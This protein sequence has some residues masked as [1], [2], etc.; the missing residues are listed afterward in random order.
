MPQRV[1]VTGGLGY[2]GSVA[3]EHFLAAGYEV[4]ALDNLMYGAGQGLFHLCA[5]PAF[6]FIKGDV[7]DESVMRNAIKGV[8]AI[9][10]LAGIVGASACDRDPALAKSVNLES[11]RLLNRL[12]SPNQLVV[13]PNT[14]SGYGATTGSALCTEDTPL[15]P[16]SLYGRTKCEAE[17]TLL[18]SPN[19]VT[20]RLAT[21][22]GLS[23]RMRLDLLVNHFVYSAVKDGYIV[24]FEKDFKRNFVHV[25]D[26]A[27]CFLHALV[28]GSKMSGRPYNLGLD[29]A[30][31]SKE[32]LA[33]AVKKQVPKFYIH[34]AA[35]GED[36][37]KRNYI[38]S[39]ARL[40]EAGFEAKRSLEDGIREL[41]KGY[42]MMGR[43]PYQNAG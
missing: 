10:H 38:V 36:P 42:R 9:V 13:F 16:I 18:D 23:P 41:I 1:L 34:F 21:V 12:R 39:S 27:D 3:C 29:S 32:Q 28:N 24:L 25:R 22:F 8:D 4:T 15:E 31:L 19:A 20:F 6:D 2:L 40:K 11:V 43:G 33:L 7:R 37:D 5:N 17:R 30:N 14:N 35:I 26:V